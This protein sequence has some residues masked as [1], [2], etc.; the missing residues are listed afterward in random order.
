MLARGLNLLRARGRWRTSA[1]A[2]L[3]LTVLLIAAPAP[4][5][6]ELKR[7]EYVER[8]EPICKAETQ[9][10]GSVLQGVEAMVRHDELKRAAP[11][12]LRAADALEAVTK[13]IAAVPRPPA[14]AAR[15]TR[16][17]AFAATG[18]ELLRQLGAE[19]GRGDRDQVQRLG[20]RILRETKRANA[21]VVGFE[22]EYCRVSPARFV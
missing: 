10:H 8:V 14:D 6:A 7:S 5:A 18:N 1:A 9:A 12:V 4:R 22:F 20:N 17:L 3:P 16:W 19:L 15:I 13:R 11:R 21:T 2:L